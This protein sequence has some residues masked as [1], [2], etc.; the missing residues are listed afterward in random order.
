M[1][2]PSPLLCTAYLKPVR[3]LG[4]VLMHLTI[5]WMLGIVVACIEW[6]RGYI[7][8]EAHEDSMQDLGGE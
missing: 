1:K 3:E 4:I 8:N 5:N 6:I 7:V 2:E